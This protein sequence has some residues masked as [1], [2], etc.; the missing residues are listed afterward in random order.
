MGGNFNAAGRSYYGELTRIPDS[1]GI[2]DLSYLLN[3]ILGS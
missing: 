3:F 1:E 2:N